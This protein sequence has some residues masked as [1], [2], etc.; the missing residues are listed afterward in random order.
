MEKCV[1][2]RVEGSNINTAYYC[3]YCSNDLVTSFARARAWLQGLVD[4]IPCGYHPLDGSNQCVCILRTVGHW[5]NQTVT[6][7]PGGGELRRQKFQPIDI[8]KLVISLSLGY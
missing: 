8:S 5:S 7:C 2:E 3:I 6:T 1:E 4:I